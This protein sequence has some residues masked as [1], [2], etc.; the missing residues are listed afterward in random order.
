MI[1]TP[2]AACGNKQRCVPET[3]MLVRAWLIFR[4]SAK[5]FQPSLPIVR[6]PA[7]RHLDWQFLT[8]G[9]C[10]GASIDGKVHDQHISSCV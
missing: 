1:N 9:L 5:A 4:P 3:L 2:A 6:Q 7:C 10:R 8:A